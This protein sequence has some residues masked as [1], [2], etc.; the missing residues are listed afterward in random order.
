M[1]GNDCITGVLIGRGH[2]CKIR[3]KD[4]TLSKT[5]ATLTFSHISGWVLEDGEFGKKISTN[6][7]WV[8]AIEEF[9]LY[10]QMFLKVSQAIFQVSLAN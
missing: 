2:H 3:I 5:H 7:T 1:T 4:E 10:N 6:G 8:Y 9:E